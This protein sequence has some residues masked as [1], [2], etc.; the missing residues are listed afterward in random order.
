VVSSSHLPARLKA[1]IAAERSMPKMHWRWRRRGRDIVALLQSRFGSVLPEDDAGADAAK[2]LAQHYMRLNIDAE[3]VTRA[4]LHLWAPWATAK[5]IARWIQDARTSKKTPSAAQLGKHWR[6]TAGEVAGLGLSTITA[7][8]VTL[9]TDRVRQSRR[10]RNAGAA[11]K[12]GR[13]ALSPEDRVAG[14]AARVRKYRA[15]HS[16]GGKPGRPKSEG[17][18][19][20]KA[21]GFN[22]KR[23]YQRHKAR[24]TVAAQNGTKNALRKI[25]HAGAY[26]RGMNRDEFS[27]TEFECHERTSA[28]DLNTIDFAKFGIT[29]IRVMRGTDE[30]LM[31]DAS[32]PQRRAQC[33]RILSTR[34]S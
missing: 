12:R 18:P 10:R 11:K 31:W 20:W 15:K 28:T 5:T 4:N 25:R 17:V 3:R 27:V 23:T 34:V 16:T 8:T 21:A 24:G 14:S 9:E 26:I 6:V 1:A 22:S 2:L 29:A 32:T 33:P 7:F 13:P 19:A 30:L